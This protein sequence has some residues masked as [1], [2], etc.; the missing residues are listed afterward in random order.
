MD[1]GLV[2]Q[3]LRL[4]LSDATEDALIQDYIDSALAHVEQ[5]CDRKIVDAP[6][7]AGEMALTKD[8]EQAV[9][10]LV[11]HWY[12]NREAAVVGAVSNDVA[13]GVERLLWYRKQF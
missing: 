10:L 11:G 5:H 8:V 12:S 4:N 13:L 9:K 7:N 2:K 1:L 6:A 3:H